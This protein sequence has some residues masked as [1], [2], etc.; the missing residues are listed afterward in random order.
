MTFDNHG[1]QYQISA[2][3]LEKLRIHSIPTFNDSA[4]VN[5]IVT[6]HTRGLNFRHIPKAIEFLSALNQII[7]RPSHDVHR[8]AE[9]VREA[10][11]RRDEEKTIHIHDNVPSSIQVIFEADNLK[12]YKWEV[13]RV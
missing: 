4:Q 3:R 13:L 12:E 5:R 11:L 9:H 6:L 10:W 1:N 8:L 7:V 2:D